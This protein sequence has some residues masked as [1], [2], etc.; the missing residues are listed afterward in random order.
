M[1]RM[2]VHQV[3]TVRRYAQRGAIQRQVKLMGPALR[4]KGEALVNA[5]HAP[6]NPVLE[7]LLRV[8]TLRR[9]RSTCRV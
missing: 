2:R 9:R 6:G 7:V 5:I 3:S 8:Q 4:R 1:E